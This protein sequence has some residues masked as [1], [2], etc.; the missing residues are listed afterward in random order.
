MFCKNNTKTG[1]VFKIGAAVELQPVQSTRCISCPRAPYLTLIAAAA[2]K[3]GHN[4]KCVNFLISIFKLL[5]G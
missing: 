5:Y 1:R 2:D 3:T 4:F